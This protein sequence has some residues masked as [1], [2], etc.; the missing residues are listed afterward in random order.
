MQISAECR[1]FTCNN[2]T[3]ESLR[4]WFFD[5]GVHGCP[6]GDTAIR[7]DCY[8]Y[9]P[10]R[11]ELG[12]KQCGNQT[13]IEIKGLVH[14]ER[15]PL[16]FG[17]LAANV[18]IWAKWTSAEMELSA[19][20]TISIK[21]TRCFRTFDTSSLEP[22]EIESSEDECPVILRKMPLQGCN[23]EFTE[24]EAFGCKW[25]SLGFEAFGQLENVEASVRRTATILVSRNPPGMPDW[26][27]ASYPQWISNAAELR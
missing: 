21:K 6:P 19:F 15:T 11:K 1:W 25:F 2:V 23:V 24:I 20:K 27:A 3:A 4:T 14:V 18:E 17:A 12:I 10:E 26:I 7:E 13:G 16:R 5:P 8:L 22:I 9:D